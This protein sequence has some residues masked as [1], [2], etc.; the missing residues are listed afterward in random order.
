MVA[1][2]YTYMT[3]R[4][5]L[6]AA[7]AA[8]ITSVAGCSGERSEAPADGD[9]PG[10]E[11]D[12]AAEAGEEDDT[13]ETGAPV[14]TVTGVTNATGRADETIVATATVENTGDATGTQRV[15]LVHDETVF[16]S[17]DPKLAPGDEYVITAEIAPGTLDVG[18]TE[19]AVVTEAE[20][21]PLLVTIERVG[22]STDDIEV[23]RHE[24]VVSRGYSTDVRVEGTVVNNADRTARSIEVTVRVYDAAG[25]QVG[26]Y[27]DEIDSVA[28]DAEAELFVDVFAD[29]DEFESY[30][31]GVTSV[32]F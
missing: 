16:E 21:R 4:R 2:R 27:T 26:S 31:V 15:E 22:P 8:G 17:G 18:E 12:P 5:F 28:P 30:D 13:E 10:D 11:S 9:P 14:F 24:L 6:L 23:L 20:S 19:L 32:D 29:P 3:S 1:G 7:T 25:D